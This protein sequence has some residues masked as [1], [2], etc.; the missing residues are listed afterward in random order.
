VS[1]HPTR[2]FIN[3]TRGTTIASAARTADNPISRFVGLLSSPPLEPGQG[4]LITPCS[5]IHMFWMKFPIDVVFFDK[6]WVVVGVL[7]N[8]RPW[9]VSP[10]YTKAKCCLELPVG[11][12]AGSGTQLGDQAEAIPIQ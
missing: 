10:L 1:N 3:R 11:A 8:I 2:S 4:L 9:R 12:I 5:Q 6:Q 7:E